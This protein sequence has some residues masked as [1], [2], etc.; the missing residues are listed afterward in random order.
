MTTV[1]ITAPHKFT[2]MPGVHMLVLGT[3][4]LGPRPAAFAD[5]LHTTSPDGA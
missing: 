2:P 4:Y 5:P 3:S 1:A